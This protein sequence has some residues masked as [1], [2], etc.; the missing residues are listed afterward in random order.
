[1]FNLQKISKK[2]QLGGVQATV[3]GLFIIAILVFAL[4]IAGAT[5]SSSTTDTTAKGVI[6]NTTA[7]FSQTATLFP[8]IGI[9]VGIVILLT[10]LLG[11]LAFY[12]NKQM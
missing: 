2:G 9:I 7:G 1:M 11:G 10:V 6:A 3:L 4:V 8:A 5:M 12:L